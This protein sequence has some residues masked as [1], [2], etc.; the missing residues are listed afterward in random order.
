M[1]TFLAILIGIGLSASAGFRI[2]TPLLLTSIATKL[3]WVTLADGFDW[4]SSTPALIAFSIALIVEIASY[5]IP[6]I[7]NFVKVIATPFAVVAGMLLTAS[8]IGDM[9]PFLS[10]GIAIIAGGGTASVT[11]LTSTAIRGTSTVVTGGIGN[12]FVSIFEGISAF[13]IAV[14]TILVPFLAI[15][16]VGII[17]ILFVIF[18]LRRRRRKVQQGLVG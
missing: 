13:V 17:I 8:F 3:S 14:G 6:V 2:F 5:Y 7:D 11:Q 9:D 15:V 12:F 4:I 16:F 10:W 1:E 18:I